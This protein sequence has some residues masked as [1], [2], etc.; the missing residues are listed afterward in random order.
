MA[1][2]LPKVN[3][4]LGQWGIILNQWL[5]HVGGYAGSQGFGDEGTGNS[6][7]DFSGLNFHNDFPTGPNITE[8][9]TFI[10]TGENRIYRRTGSDWQILLQADGGGGSGDKDW[11]INDNNDVAQNI[12]Q[13]IFRDGRVGIGIKSPS[14]PLHILRRDAEVGIMVHSQVATDTATT[15]RAS[16]NIRTEKEGEDSKN[17]FIRNEDGDLELDARNGNIKTTDNVRINGGNLVM[18]GNKPYDVGQFTGSQIYTGNGF[19]G[20]QGA[21]A[22]SLV[23]NGVRGNNDANG[24]IVWRRLD[25]ATNPPETSATS[26]TINLIQMLDTG[27]QFLNIPSATTSFSVDN[28][29]ILRMA[30]GTDG[31]VGIGTSTPTN[32][33]HVNATADPLKLVGLTVKTAPTDVL[34][35]DSGGVVYK[36]PVSSLPGSGGGGNGGGNGGGGDQDW[37]KAEGDPIANIETSEI[38]TDIK[39]N[40]YT[41]G[42]VGIG[43][44]PGTKTLSVRGPLFVDT[45]T[46]NSPDNSEQNWP[47]Q[48][49]SANFQGRGIIVNG[50]T[51]RGTGDPNTEE[52]K[53]AD[54]RAI[55]VPLSLKAN[56]GLLSE[57]NDETAGNEAVAGIIYNVTPVVDLD[58]FGID[59]TRPV[60]L[61]SG[62]LGAR[63]AKTAT[64]GPFDE[65][66]IGVYGGCIQNNYAGAF[67][68]RVAIRVNRGP[69]FDP[70]NPLSNL[71]ED[72]DYVLE[73]NIFLFDVERNEVNPSPQNALARFANGRVLIENGTLFLNT[74]QVVA[75]S[76]ERLKTNIIQ[77]QSP[78]EKISKI[79]GVTFNWKDQTK[80]QKKQY[81]VIAQ[82]VEK[83]F[84][85]L[86]VDDILDDKYKSVN[87]LGLITPLIE[88]VKELKQEIESLKS[89]I[90]DLK[91]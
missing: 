74:S 80:N 62:I 60:S 10:H 73:N 87:Y 65:E 11:V 78:L 66:I 28:K 40:I 3:G 84:P 86:V 4:D 88:S 44:T 52:N 35:V 70:N 83:V 16:I 26:T 23:W 77:I 15:P 5:K 43:R 59:N 42:K 71:T 64:N 61:A 1:R 14:V 41:L 9:F 72:N 63:Y 48:E 67:E 12:T 54:T 57:V 39:D 22:M 18:G 79:R 45:A 2:R 6:Q 56:T 91:K 81:G 49:W 8:G 25:K 37:L 85:E 29:P 69:E 47:E 82:E 46:L 36:R 13:A 27:I 75:S 33:L 24:N 34:V 7:G 19:I 51:R 17:I 38:P 21:H 76:D 32:K 20:T 53:D 58:L 89:E 31:N 90:A 30:I 55:V 68:G 50:K